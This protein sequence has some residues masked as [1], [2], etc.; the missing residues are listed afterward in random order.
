MLYDIPEEL[1]I[2]IV[3]ILTLKETVMLATTCK[4]LHV[5][6]K[7]II[8]EYYFD[9]YSFVSEISLLIEA[10]LENDQYDHIVTFKGNLTNI[11]FKA[12]FPKSNKIIFEKYI[13]MIS[14]NYSKKLITQDVYY[15]QTYTETKRVL[16]FACLNDN[17]IMNTA[18]YPASKE[19]RYIVE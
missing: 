4:I 15:T 16:K 6:L 14:N 1:F 5:Q 8:R 13:Q 17:D 10:N 3:N 18:F 7:D 11:I 12:R 2:K 9:Y 19:F